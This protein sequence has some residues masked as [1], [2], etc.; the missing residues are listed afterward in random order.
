MYI[1]KGINEEGKANG[2]RERGES[3]IEEKR[4]K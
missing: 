4:K 2:K 3:K 1:I